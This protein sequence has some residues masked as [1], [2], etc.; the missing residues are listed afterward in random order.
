MLVECSCK[1]I[2]LTTNAIQQEAQIDSIQKS[3]EEVKKLEQQLKDAESGFQDVDD[4]GF[5]LFHGIYPSKKA[6]EI[7]EPNTSAVVTA[8][9]AVYF[10]FLKQLGLLNAVI[11]WLFT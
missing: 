10:V 11:A 7:P 5:K 9:K 4:E 6:K 8:I 2:K 3:V 1:L